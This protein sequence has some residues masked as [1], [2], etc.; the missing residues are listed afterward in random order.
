MGKYIINRI[1]SGLVVLFTILTLVFILMRLIPGNPIY[2][3]AG[4]GIT[5]EDLIALQEKYGL[6]DS[7]PVQYFKYLSNILRGDWGKSYFN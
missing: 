5:N 6:N 3:I 4:E 1:L 7:L 2:S